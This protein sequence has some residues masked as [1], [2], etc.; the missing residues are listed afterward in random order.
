MPRKADELEFETTPLS[1]MR[2][3]IVE[4]VVESHASI[5]VFHMHAQADAT[6]LVSARKARKEASGDGPTPTYNDF[7][8]KIV[9]A[10]LQ[11]HR[12]F[13]AWFDLEDGLKIARQVNVAFAVAT[14]HGVLLP[15]V[16]DADKKSVREIAG[17]TRELAD[18]AREGKLRASLQM[19]ATFT[20][21]NVGPVGINA[22]NAIINQKQTGILAIGSLMP[23]PVAVGDEVVIRQVLSLTLSV[24]HRAA[25]GMD[26]ALFLADV[27]RGVEEW[28]NE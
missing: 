5:P 18:L 2:R 10:S 22:F 11:T 15:T 7:I 26:G 17:E 19:G 14:E 28:E 1:A 3:A 25:D 12:R 23:Q 16:F 24:D 4:R 27:K 21:S 6:R 20:I 8:I 9:A 13:N